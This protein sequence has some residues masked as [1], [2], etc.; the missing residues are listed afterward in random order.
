MILK[1]MMIRLLMVLAVLALQACNPGGAPK[2]KAVATVN[3][4]PITAAELR[5]EVA[6]Y[7]KNNPITRQTVEDQLK[8][9]IE[10]KLLIQ[11]AVRMG[12]SEDP[13]FAETIKTFWEQTIIRN[14]IDAKTRELSGQVFVTDQELAGEYE[15]MKHRLRMRAV[16][17]A[18]TKQDADTIAGR[19]QGGRPVEGEEIIGPLFYEDVKGSPLAA[20][21][22]LKEGQTGSFFT[23]GEYVA[24]CVTGREAVSLPPRSELDKRIR[25]SV[26]LQ[27]RQKALTEWIADVKSKAKVQIDEKELG[28][29]VHE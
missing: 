20:A 5:Q 15:R 8:I 3:D 19:M 24:L 9:M 23:G 27:K 12:L 26:V 16:R 10:Q 17:G 1:E 2:E 13:K 29:I 21:F 11:E 22:D 4:A 18:R 7:G 25:E 6:G 14:L 28:R